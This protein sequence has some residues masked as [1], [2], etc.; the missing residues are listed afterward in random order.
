MIRL[1]TASL[2][3]CLAPVVSAI[4]ITWTLNDVIFFD[5]AEAIGVFDFDAETESFSNVSIQTTTGMLVTPLSGESEPFDGADYDDAI[6][7][8]QSPSNIAAFDSGGLPDLTGSSTLFLNFSQA[9]SEAGGVVDI[10]NGV[11][12]ECRV[13]LCNSFD[14]VNSAIRPVV[15]GSVIADVSVPVPLP[16]TVALMVLGLAGLGW[17]RRKRA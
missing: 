12:Y 16:A 13:P 11:E 17:S 7:S 6:A 3:A 1:I 9:L 2:L 14:P 10:L 15:G 4:P 5:G 8:I